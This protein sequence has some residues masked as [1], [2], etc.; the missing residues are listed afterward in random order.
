VGGSLSLGRAATV[1]LDQDM[2]A[3]TDTIAVEVDVLD[4]LDVVGPRA[5]ELDVLDPLTSTT[6]SRPRRSPPR[7]ARCC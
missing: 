4:A 6:S 1:R 7:R 2:I 3:R 5:I